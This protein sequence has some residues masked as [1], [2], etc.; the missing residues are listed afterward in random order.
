MHD[1]RTDEAIDALLAGRSRHRGRPVTALTTV[2]GSR[3][4]L[5]LENRIAWHD[6]L[7]RENARLQ[8]YGRAASIVAFHLEPL[9][10]D[11]RAG[12]WVERV[13][14]PVAHAIRRG[15][16]E[17]DLV[18]RA[19]PGLFEVML[20]ETTESEAAAFADRVVADCHV[21]LEAMAAPVTLR[22]AAAGTASDTDLEATLDRALELLP[23]D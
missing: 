19:A 20:P 4:S 15:A 8:R 16:R 6:A 13:A 23:G 5:A 1:P 21:W 3:S 12:G 17:T 9:T 14:P 11:A 18:T 7:R 10:D 2:D 22:A